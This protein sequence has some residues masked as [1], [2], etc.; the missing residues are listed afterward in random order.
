MKRYDIISGRKYQSNGEDK[1]HW[2]KCGAAFARDR[3]GFGIVL[4][5]IPTTTNDKGQITFLM[6]EPT[7]RDSGGG[8]RRRESSGSG[9]GGYSDADY[10][11]GKDDD[12]LPF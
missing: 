7:E 1:T 10:G 11:P 8:G 5:F 2:T 9:G 3:G 6:V 12:P 4:D